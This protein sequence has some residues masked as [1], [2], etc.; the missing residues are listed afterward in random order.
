MMFNMNTGKD[1]A[2]AWEAMPWVLQGT[3]P[4]EQSEWLMKHLAHCEACRAEYAQQGQLRRAASLPSDI[5]IDAEAGLK[6]LLARIDAPAPDAVAT[7]PRKWLTRALAAAVLLQAL[8]LGVLGTKVWP[9]HN[10]QYR[11]LSRVSAPEP[12]GAIR[13]VPAAGLKLDDWN[14]LLRNLQLRVVD[15]PNAMGAYTVVPSGGTA[16]QSVQ[17]L[18]ASRDVRLAE[19]VGDRP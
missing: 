9:S 2:H 6:R 16:T 13:V 14:K 12:R 8:G 15:G 7:R 19:L 17:Q 1:C 5:R 18:R 10:P 3:A 4:P 11:T